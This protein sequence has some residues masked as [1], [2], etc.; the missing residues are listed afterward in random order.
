MDYD[1]LVDYLCLSDIHLVRLFMCINGRVMLNSI[2]GKGNLLS[3]K[4]SYCKMGT[5]EQIKHF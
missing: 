2:T 5:K 4:Y 1:C 3:T